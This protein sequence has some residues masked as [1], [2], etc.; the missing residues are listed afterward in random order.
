MRTFFC[1]LTGLFCSLSEQSLLAQTAAPAENNTEKSPELSELQK[2]FSN[3]PEQK[4]IDYLKHFEEATR[5][6]NQKR[7]F[8]AFNEIDEAR[9]I[10]DKNSDLF[11]LMASCYVEFR[12]FKNA[13]IYYKKASALAPKSPVIEFNIAELLFVTRKWEECIKKMNEVLT[14]LPKN[15]VTTRRIVEFK[16]MLC[17]IGLGQNDKANEWA[18]KY[19]PLLD[20]S[21]F[22]YYANAAIN[23]R[24]KKMVKAEEFLQ[25][26]NHVFANPAILNPWQDTLIEFGYIAS[27][28]GGEEKAEEK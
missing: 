19:D 20:D 17:Q 1:L 16:I 12:D 3:L 22:Y 9:K 11:N 8:E 27:F 13:D 15:D 2:E 25:T 4:R 10:F 23:F 26:A 7:I 28:Y 5:L 21:P 24:D 14:L 18:N 6:F